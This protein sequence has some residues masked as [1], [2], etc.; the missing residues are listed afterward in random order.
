M[1]IDID[2]Y[3]SSAT[4]QWCDNQLKNLDYND[5]KVNLEEF[6]PDEIRAHCKI[7]LQFREI[8]QQHVFSHETSILS[9]CEK[10]K[11]AW[12]WRHNSNSKLDLI[13]ELDMLEKEL[14]SEQNFQDMMNDIDEIIETER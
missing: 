14:D 9:E 11:K 5:E 12:K 8:I 3:L 4:K 13:S 7:Y 6:F 2:E 1:I 10:S